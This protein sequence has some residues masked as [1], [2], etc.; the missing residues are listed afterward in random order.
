M[1]PNSASSAGTPSAPDCAARRTTSGSAI[2]I[3]NC[4]P[5]APRARSVAGR[6]TLRTAT[7]ASA[8]RSAPA[9]PRGR[10]GPALAG[11]GEAAEV[12][13]PRAV[14]LRLRTRTPARRRAR[15]AVQQSALHPPV[16]GAAAAR[17]EPPARRV[18]DSSAG[19]EPGARGSR[20]S[21]NHAA[22]HGAG[23]RA[24]AVGYAV[25]GG[26]GAAEPLAR[27]RR[28][29]GQVPV[30]I[31]EP[32]GAAVVEGELRQRSGRLRTAAETV[33]RGHARRT[34]AGIPQGERSG[35]EVP[36]MHTDTVLAKDRHRQVELRDVVDVDPQARPLQLG[37][38]CNPGSEGAVLLEQ[39]A[40]G[41]E[42]ARVEFA[43]ESR[44]HLQNREHL[45]EEQLVQRGRLVVVKTGRRGCRE[46]VQDQGGAELVAHD[47]GDLARLLGVALLALHARGDAHHDDDD[48][49]R[50]TVGENVDQGDPRE[51][52]HAP[53]HPDHG[54]A[55]A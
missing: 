43:H 35:Q 51:V 50:H 37:H 13:G 7:L 49:H 21:R 15:R 18:A 52:G 41:P 48:E 4:G 6:L 1:I 26:A 14:G 19:R 10:R 54:A 30:E 5:V 29:V 20:G 2:R 53:G 47:R 27:S 36:V 16:A 31:L 24:A 32:A 44:V 40:A 25:A 46:A 55:S 42:G 23:C 28:H 3:L 45:R 9:H 22:G 17:A 38:S 34:S 39:L 12:R 8:R 11:V 33:L